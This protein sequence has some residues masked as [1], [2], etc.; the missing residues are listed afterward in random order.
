MASVIKRVAFQGKALIFAC[1]SIN[2]MAK[3]IQLKSKTRKR[4]ETMSMFDLTSESS[5]GLSR[6]EA[7]ERA[8]TALLKQP[9]LS[10]IRDLQQTIDLDPNF[11]AFHDRSVS[12]KIQNF[13]SR[14]G[15]FWDT[16]VFENQFPKLVNEAVARVK[17]LE[18]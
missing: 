18:K 16:E 1:G 6:V 9:A 11:L 2:S 13:L 15:I 7:D 14:Q 4:T 17:K 10:Y 8:V 3:S 12:L 5:F